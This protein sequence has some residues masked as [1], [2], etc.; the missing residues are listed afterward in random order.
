MKVTSGVEQS[1][2]VLI[3]LARQKDRQP[4]KSETLAKVLGVSES[5]LRKIIRKLVVAELV[6]S[7]ASRT[8]G[9]SLAKDV[10]EI[11][12]HDILEAVEAGSS[13]Y[14]PSLEGRVTYSN[15]L[16]F[17]GKSKMANEIFHEAF[18]AFD[19][20][21]QNY[22]IA[23]VLESGVSGISDVDWNEIIQE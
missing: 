6:E 9:I 10:R 23:D 15:K 17:E 12:F 22:T 16:D 3:V 5:Y 19:G 18:T 7:N 14:T 13:R 8:G 2:Y 1:I 21:L 20:V 11:T 4:L